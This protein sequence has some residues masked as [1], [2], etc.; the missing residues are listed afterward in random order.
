MIS[1][2]DT[3]AGDLPK[4]GPK[5]GPD[6]EPNSEPNSGYFDGPTHILPVRVYY[7]DTD[8]AG[9][10][11]YANYLRFMERG[12]SDMFR[13]LDLHP[14]SL[15]IAGGNRSQETLFVVR[16]CEVEYLRPARLNEALHVRT[17]LDKVGGA[18][19]VMKQTVTRDGATLVEAIVRIASVRADGHPTRMPAK[20][21]DVFRSL[22]L[23]NENIG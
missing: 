6:S 2:S 5:S 21:R 15:E 10:V 16:R 11:Y 19:V 23:D 22:M 12:R 14:V 3:Q 18:S 8:S 13:L 1:N 9:I 7:E 17:S 4:S 20:T